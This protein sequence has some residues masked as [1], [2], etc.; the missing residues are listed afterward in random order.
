MDLSG[1]SYYE[2]DRDNHLF[3]E[4]IYIKRTLKS[5]TIEGYEQFKKVNLTEAF[6]LDIRWCVLDDF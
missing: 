6:K 3:K 1:R 4:C 5:Q 2:L